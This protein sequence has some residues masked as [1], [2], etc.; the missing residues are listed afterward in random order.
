MEE[1][2]ECRTDER[3]GVSVRV[4]LAFGVTQRMPAAGVGH[5]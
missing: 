1:R 4:Y 2:A 3:T 5:Q